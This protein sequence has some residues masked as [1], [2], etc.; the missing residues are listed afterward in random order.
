MTADASPSAVEA[1]HAMMLATHPIHNKQH[2]DTLKA[3]PPADTKIM[4]E[5]MWESHM[6]SICE[7]EII[8]REL[9]KELEML[10]EML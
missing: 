10:D 6:N 4:L 7:H 9:E 8:I 5:A 2:E 1:R 3:I